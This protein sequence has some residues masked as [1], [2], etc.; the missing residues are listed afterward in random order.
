MAHQLILRLANELRPPICIREGR[1]IGHIDLRVGAYPSDGDGPVCALL[2]EQGYHSGLGARSLYQIIEQ[3]IRMPLADILEDDEE[4]DENV[5][6][7]GP[8]LGY[9]A[10]RQATGNQDQQLIVVRPLA[11]GDEK[12][13]GLNL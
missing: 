8:S 2:A 9:S 13:V 4:I 3:R 11:I 1:L 12:V 5:I 10:N 6:N 7:K